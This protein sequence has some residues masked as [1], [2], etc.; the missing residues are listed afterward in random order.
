MHRI[1]TDKL[2]SIN[3]YRHDLALHN[4]YKDVINVIFYLFAVF[5]LTWLIPHTQR[6]ESK[7]LRRSVE[8]EQLAAD[9]QKGIS[10]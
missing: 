2:I 3:V 9:R 7:Q 4:N 1:F 8:I 5:H 10:E 6:A